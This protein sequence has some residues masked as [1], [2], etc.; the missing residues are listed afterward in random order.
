M[1]G[2]IVGIAIVLLVE[3]LIRWVKAAPRDSVGTVDRL[4]RRR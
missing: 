4:F 3:G 2:Y 1:I